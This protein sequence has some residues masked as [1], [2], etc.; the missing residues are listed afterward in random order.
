M[1][2]KQAVRWWMDTPI[3]DGALVKGTYTIQKCLG[4]GG[5]GITYECSHAQSGEEYVLKQLRPSKSR[6]EKDKTRFVREAQLLERID[7]EWIPS[8]VEAFIYEDQWFFVMEKIEAPNLEDLL[9]HRKRT[10]TEWEALMIGHRITEI[11]DYLH[12]KDIYHHDIRLPNLLLKGEYV[13]L[14]D[15]GLANEAWNKKEREK[16]KLG[17]YYDLGETLLFL[18]YTQYT[19]NISKKRSWMDELT[20]NRETKHL[21]QGLLGIR[22]EYH[23]TVSIRKD[24]NAALS[25][26]N[27]EPSPSA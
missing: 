26:L 14:I 27:K 19:G 24:L 16:G 20:L 5:Y 25:S 12:K 9:F 11:M 18:L 10:F 1:I 8:F 2:W 3:K 6:R 23:S 22:G 4:M 13:Y 15:F 17:D 7:Y 21:L